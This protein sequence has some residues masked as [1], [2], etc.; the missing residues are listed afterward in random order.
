MTM[1]RGTFVGNTPLIKVP[2][3]WSQAVQTPFVVLDTGFTGDLQVSS[4]IAQELGLNITGVTPVR[5]ATGQIVQVPV[6]IA[7]TAMEGITK[8]I[9]VLIS[10]GVPLA[11]IGFLSKFNYRACF[12]CKNK[13]VALETV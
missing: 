10:D 11:G 3:A 5:I 2:V 9:E 13:T 6:A 12:D 1:K 4:K 8:R 7:L